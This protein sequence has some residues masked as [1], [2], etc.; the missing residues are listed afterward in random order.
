MSP[1]IFQT[2]IKQWFIKLKHAVCNCSDMDHIMYKSTVLQVYGYSCFLTSS[3]FSSRVS[4]GYYTTYLLKRGGYKFDALV[5]RVCLSVASTLQKES[6]D[7]NDSIIF[8]GAWRYPRYVGSA[9]VFFFH[10]PA[11]R[12]IRTRLFVDHV[13][14]YTIHPFFV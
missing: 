7:F 1:C 10:S 3:N 14:L 4:G 13:V 12:H 6:S 9:L 5:S 2:F 8:K 11:S